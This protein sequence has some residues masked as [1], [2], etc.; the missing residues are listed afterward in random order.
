MPVSNAIDGIQRTF[1]EIGAKI[2]YDKDNLNVYKALFGLDLNKL[3]IVKHC[4]KGIK[5]ES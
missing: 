1:Q 3:D 4:L 2:P 5:M